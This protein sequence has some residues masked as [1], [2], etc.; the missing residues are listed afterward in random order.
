MMLRGD[1]MYQLAQS[2]GNVQYYAYMPKQPTHRVSDRITCNWKMLRGQLL[3]QWRHINASELDKIG[4]N[5]QRIAR[6]IE[7]E[8]GVAAELVE[9][10]L[11][12]FERTMPL[13][14]NS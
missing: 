6:L 4:P 7:R 9:N 5:R 12:N 14:A 13:A 11:R 1:V 8:Y 3:A 10:Y 2:Y